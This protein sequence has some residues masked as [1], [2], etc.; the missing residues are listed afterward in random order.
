[1]AHQVP[2]NKIILE[3]FIADAMLT[4]EEEMVIRTRIAGWSRTQQ[5]IELGISESTL[6]R[7]I[8]RLKK[9]YDNAAKY[10]LLLPPR[11]PSEKET[12]QDNN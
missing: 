8:K 5:C 7:M 2:W 3:S 4:K 9:K 6:D 1:M 12:W 11:K 10:N